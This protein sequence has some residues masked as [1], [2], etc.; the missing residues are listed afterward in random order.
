MTHPTDLLAEYA[1]GTLSEETKRR[2]AAHL[3]RCGQCAAELSAWRRV[4]GAARGAA[5]QVAPPPVG[6]LRRVLARATHRPTVPSYLAPRWHRPMP[7]AVRILLA[8]FR[9]VAWQ[10]WVLAGVLL[11]IGTAI[12]ATAPEAAAV[13]RAL[14]GLVP[15][16]VAVGVAGA[17]GV[18]TEPVAELVAASGTSPRT[19]LLARLTVVMGAMFAVAT[20]VALAT[21]E[22]AGMSP[23]ALLAA[24]LGPMTLLSAVSFALA[25]LW[26]PRSAITIA[27]G[28]WAARLFA[29]TDDRFA[30]FAA[31]IWDTTIPAIAVAG[32]LVAVTVLVAPMVHRT[33]TG[34]VA[35]SSY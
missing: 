24:W 3:A 8:Q 11:L 16:F 22:L 15:P 29:L 33:S 31:V 12:A 23:A 1:A 4:A 2:T 28:L 17:C 21:S 19:V 27:A 7:R 10:T 14:S 34:A 5:A 25:V 20:G 30:A 35:F 32:V 13:E 9:L 26:R 6:L 18:A